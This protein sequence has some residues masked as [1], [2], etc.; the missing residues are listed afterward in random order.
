M[1]GTGLNFENGAKVYVSFIY[2][3]RTGSEEA[4]EVSLSLCL[5]RGGEADA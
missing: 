5:K 4:I 1:P 3:S 2:S